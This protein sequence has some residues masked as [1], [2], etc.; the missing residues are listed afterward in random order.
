MKKV[1]VNY[2][3]GAVESTQAEVEKILAIFSGNGISHLEINMVLAAYTPK[4]VGKIICILCK[5]PAFD[6]VDNNMVYTFVLRISPDRDIL[7]YVVKLRHLL[8]RVDFIDNGCP[9]QKLKKIV[10]AFRRRNVLCSLCVGTVSSEDLK[11]LGKKSAALGVPVL[12]EGYLDSDSSFC[13][14]FCRWL[15]DKQGGRIDLFTDILAKIILDDWGTK[16]QYKS[17]LTKSIYIDTKADIF[18]CR[19]DKERICNLHDIQSLQDIYVNKSFLMCLERAVRHRE[20]CKEKCE[21]YSMCNGGCPLHL[22]IYEDVCREQYFFEKLIKLRGKICYVIQNEDYN[23]LNPVVKD[24]ILSG[25]ASNKIF[26]MGLY[27]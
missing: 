11:M 13:E 5:M 23:N 21:H 15:Y 8:R 10:L 9:D 22:D 7:H 27:P 25:V 16:C 12:T 1:T 2:S 6:N 17:C 24:L 20:K 19:N 14:L 4:E 18:L 26:E 3:P